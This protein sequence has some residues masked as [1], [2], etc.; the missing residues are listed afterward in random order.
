MFGCGVLSYFFLGGF[1]DY[2]GIFGVLGTQAIFFTILTLPVG[3]YLYLTESSTHQSTLGKRRV[4]IKVVKVSGSKPSRKNI[5][6]RTVVK[7]LPW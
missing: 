6:L 4:G 1:P 3:L 7:L 5:L 2:L